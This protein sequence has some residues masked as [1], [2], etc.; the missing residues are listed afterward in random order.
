MSASL[1]LRE[2][3]RLGSLTLAA[4]MLPALVY[5]VILVLR[6]TELR[7]EVPELDDA[8]GIAL[9][10]AVIVAPWILG[11]ASFAP[12][13]ESGAASFLARLPLPTWKLLSIRLAAIAVC[14]AGVHAPVWAL[15][16]WWDMPFRSW[17]LLGGASAISLALLVGAIYASL[18][19]KRSLSAFAAG[20]VLVWTGLYVVV[21][22][23]V[24]LGL[25]F[26][27]EEVFAGLT[28]LGL[29]ILGSVV[30]AAKAQK[31]LAGLHPIRA[32]W[33]PVA[34]LCLL[35]V[36]TAAAFTLY[37][38]S[39]FGQSFNEVYQGGGARGAT[40]VDSRGSRRIHQESRAILVRGGKVAV[41]PAGHTL[42]GLS[43]THAYTRIWEYG[44]RGVPREASL[45]KLDDLTWCEP[46]A[47]VTTPEAAG[48]HDLIRLYL[49]YSAKGALGHSNPQ[50]LWVGDVPCEARTSW[51]MTATRRQLYLPDNWTV[52]AAAGSSVIA[53]TPAGDLH[54]FRLSPESLERLGE[55]AAWQDL[56][57]LFSEITSLQ[58]V[59]P[60]RSGECLVGY[61]SDD[62][63]LVAAGLDL[64]V[65]EPRPVEI[66][67]PPQAAVAQWPYPASAS[68][69]AVRWGHWRDRAQNT[70]TWDP[71][72]PSPVDPEVRLPVR[73]GEGFGVQAF[74]LRFGAPGAWGE[75]SLPD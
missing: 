59:L 10:L 11:A 42:G 74:E 37:D 32:T 64:R 44:S 65:S 24:L 28:L 75:V 4:W 16:S 55:P 40:L 36:G 45:W 9:A 48:R 21:L 20:P 58:D 60:S 68:A 33:R 17:E 49:G 13:R 41:L 34:L 73:G 56:G 23:W 19:F 8:R 30:W 26:R 54:L 5:G 3:K 29:G 50:V 18:S 47:L 62:Q 61:G 35:N 67:R 39:H 27:E 63:G 66:C 51:I 31:P 22:P 71:S 72:P 15:A 46:D 69:V 12:E 6:Q 70:R 38:L 7:G 53:R 14:L 1:F 43:P 2:L 57:E 25:R 52:R